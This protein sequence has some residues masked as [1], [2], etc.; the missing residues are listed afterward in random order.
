MRIMM[1][2]ILTHTFVSAM[3]FGTPFMASADAAVEIIDQE[4]Q[5]INITVNGSIMHV[6]GANGQVLQIYNVAGVCVK[7]IKVEGSDKLYDLNL[8]KGCY[9]VKVGKAVRKISINR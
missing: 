7:S 2:R 9:I 3:L 5:N 1:K 6:T 4:F 8:P